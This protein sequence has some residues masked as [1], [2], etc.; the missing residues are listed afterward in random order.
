MYTTLYTL[1]EKLLTDGV[2]DL[3]PFYIVQVG[4]M[5]GR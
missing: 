5:E 1:L 4:V 2:F 3:T